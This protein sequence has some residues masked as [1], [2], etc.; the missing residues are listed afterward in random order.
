MSQWSNMLFALGALLILLSQVL[1]ALSY[2]GL[3]QL[4][5]DII[6]TAPQTGLKIVFPWVTCAVIS[7]VINC[8][9]YWFN[10]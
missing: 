6:Y 8:A 10:R 9:I 5:G 3:G 2:L 1:P 4:P 7:I